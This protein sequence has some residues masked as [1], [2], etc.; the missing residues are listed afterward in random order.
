[1][2]NYFDKGNEMNSGKNEMLCLKFRQLLGESSTYTEGISFMKNLKSA[3]VLGVLTLAAIPAGTV[4]SAQVCEAETQEVLSAFKAGASRRYSAFETRKK[5]AELFQFYMKFDCNPEGTLKTKE[6]AAK[7][8]SEIPGVEKRL[9]E[10]AASDPNRIKHLNQALLDIRAELAKTNFLLCVAEASDAKKCKATSPSKNPL[11]TRTETVPPRQIADAS[12]P[13]AAKGT[14]SSSTPGNLSP[15]QVITC[16]EEIKNK[17]IE[18]QSW[19]G[20]VNDV[21]A[22]LGQFQKSLF[23]GRCAGHP[24]AQAYIAGANKMLGYGGNAAGSGGSSGG[25]QANVEIQGSPQC[26]KYYIVSETPE[27]RTSDKMFSFGIQNICNFPVYIHWNGYFNDVETQSID[28]SI[29][30]KRGTNSRPVF[31]PGDKIEA[32]PFRIANKRRF[33][34]KIHSV[35]PTEAEATRLTGKRIDRVVQGAGGMCIAQILDT[36]G[37]RSSQ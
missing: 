27:T 18:S 24:E 11:T 4:Q 8:A 28:Y 25:S 29:Q 9:S 22:R 15:Q 1:M 7:I 36:R 17:Q 32:I 37:V 20:D 6:Y 12:P 34:A 5:G 19:G 16:S 10:V 14:G 35:C 23:E 13:S 2:K 33:Y 3:L 30:L 21:A 31:G 26:V